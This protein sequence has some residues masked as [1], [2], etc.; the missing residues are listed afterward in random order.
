[1]SSTHQGE[2]MK[3]QILLSALAIAIVQFAPLPAW[4]HNHWGGGYGGYGG[5]Y[6]G[7]YCHH[8]HWN[9]MGYGNSYGNMYRGNMGYGGGYGGY[10]SYGG[11]NNYG[12][13]YG[14]YGTSAFGGLSRMMRGF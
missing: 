6:G 13:G 11:Y 14:G 3:W 7:N 4:S 12:G 5:G 10:P 9:N 2:A 1:M 8:H